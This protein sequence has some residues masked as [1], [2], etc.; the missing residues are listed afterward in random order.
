VEKRWVTMASLYTTH[1]KLAGRGSH[2]ARNSFGDLAQFSKRT[3]N[4]ARAIRICKY[5]R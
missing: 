5:K 4:T 2:V 1:L 3:G